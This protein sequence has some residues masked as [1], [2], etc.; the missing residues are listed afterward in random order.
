MKR[1]ILLCNK[2]YWSS[3]GTVSEDAYILNQEG[4][5]FHHRIPENL[6]SKRWKKY[7]KS[8]PKSKREGLEKT[9]IRHRA[10]QFRKYEKSLK[11]KKYFRT[12]VSSKNETETTVKI[13]PMLA[14]T[15]DKLAKRNLI[16]DLD[17]GYRKIALDE[18]LPNSVEN[19]SVKKEPKV[20]N[21]SAGGEYIRKWQNNCM[22]IL[23]SNKNVITVKDAMEL[24]TGKP[25]LN[26]GLVPYYA[27]VPVKI[28]HPENNDAP[29]NFTVNAWNVTSKANFR[30]L[31]GLLRVPNVTVEENVERFKPEE[32]IF[33]RLKSDMFNGCSFIVMFACMY[34]L[35]NGLQ[36]L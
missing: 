29:I 27:V 21:S 13:N 36:R 17:A 28:Q 19:W 25:K 24:S 11:Y 7:L 33:D 5:I 2:N 15:F 20:W 22:T 30:R 9:A 31:H 12:N 35:V 16:V 26:K 34:Q 3:K 14:E 8:Q 10:V 4:Q 18:K 32:P 6:P 23:D 1:S